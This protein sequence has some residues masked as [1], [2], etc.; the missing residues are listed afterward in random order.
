MITIQACVP[1][2]NKVNLKRPF[3]FISKAPLQ[4]WLSKEAHRLFCEYISMFFVENKTALNSNLKSVYFYS[5]LFCESTCTGSWPSRCRNCSL[6]NT[7]P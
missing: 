7:A 6:G 2:L 3:P 1:Y 4:K 5:T